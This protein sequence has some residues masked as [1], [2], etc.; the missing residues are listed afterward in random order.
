VRFTAT[1]DPITS[2]VFI[3]GS[4]LP[5]CHATV[6][7]FNP[8]GTNFILRSAQDMPITRGT[9]HVQDTEAPFDQL[10]RY[11]VLV[12]IATSPADNQLIQRNLIVNPSFETNTTSWTAGTG[13]TI[14]RVTL[15]SAGGDTGDTVPFDISDIRPTAGNTLRLAIPADPMS[16]LAWSPSTSQWYVS[17]NKP[18]TASIAQSTVI[19]RVSATGVFLDSMVLVNG[20]PGDQ[21][22]VQLINGEIWVWTNYQ[23]VDETTNVVMA[24]D[25]ARVRYSPGDKI[26]GDLTSADLVLLN[27]FTA[28]AA[29]AKLDLANDYVLL[30][31]ESGT[32]PTRTAT[33]TRRKYSEM[34]TSTNTTYGQVGPFDIDLDNPSGS[35][36]THQGFALKQDTL[37]R[38]TGSADENDPYEIKAYTITGTGIDAPDAALQYTVDVSQTGVPADGSPVGDYYEGGGLSLYR[39][40]S[41]ELVLVQGISTGTSTARLNQPYLY[42]Q[43]ASEAVGSVG[44][45]A[46]VGKNVL[47]ATPRTTQVGDSTTDPPDAPIARI[48]VTMPVNS[49]SQSYEFSLNTRLNDDPLSYDFESEVTIG[50]DPVTWGDVFSTYPNWALP[51][52]QELTWGDLTYGYIADVTDK[53]LPVVVQPD[54]PGLTSPDGQWDPVAETLTVPQSRIDT[55]GI[56]Y[57]INPTF[58]TAASPSLTGYTAAVTSGTLPQLSTVIIDESQPSDDSSFSAVPIM[59]SA[60]QVILAATSVN[61]TVRFTVTGLTA[62]QEY[63]AVTDLQL[64]I[65]ESMWLSTHNGN[66]MSLGNVGDEFNDWMS[67][68]VTF[69]AAS[70]TETITMLFA[71]NTAGTATIDHVLVSG[72]SVDYFDGDMPLDDEYFYT[73]LGTPHQSQSRRTA[74]AM[75]LAPT[76]DPNPE[77]QIGW[78]VSPI[79]NVPIKAVVGVV[80]PDGNQLIEPVTQIISAGG[81][82]PAPTNLQSNM[83]LN[84]TVTTLGGWMNMLSTTTLSLGTT[85]PISA[86]SSALSTVTTS[87]SDYI[88]YLRLTGGYLSASDPD[89]LSQPEF[90]AITPI[91][92]KVMSW[93]MSMK[94]DLDWEAHVGLYTV[95]IDGNQIDGVMETFT[96]V[97]NQVNRIGCTFLVPPGSVGVFCDVDVDKTVSGMTVIGTRTWLDNLLVELDSGRTYEPADIMGN[98]SAGVYDPAW[99][100]DGSMSGYSWSGVAG[101]STTIVNATGP[102]VSVLLPIADTTDWPP[103]WQPYVIVEAV[104]AKLEFAT[105]YHVYTRPLFS[106]YQIQ[107][108]AR[109][110]DPTNHVVATLPLIDDAVSVIDWTNA[111]W[112]FTMPPT[113]AGTYKIEV[114]PQLTWEGARTAWQLDGVMLQKMP[115]QD[116]ALSYL[117]GSMPVPDIGI[118]GWIAPEEQS[119]YDTDSGNALIRWTGTAHASTSEFLG[120]SAVT[121]VREAKLDVSSAIYLNLLPDCEPINL[122]DPMLP[123]LN[124]WFTLQLISELS[125]E[126]RNVSY[127]VLNRHAPVVLSQVRSTATGSLTLLLKTLNERQRLMDLVATGR[128]LLLRNPD[129]AYPESDWYLAI[130]NV[131]ESRIAPDHRLAYRVFTLEFAVV[132]R[133]S[134]PI[135]TRP[136]VTWDAVIAAYTSWGPALAPNSVLAN[137]KTWDELIHTQP[138]IDSPLEL[139]GSYD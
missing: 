130:G 83:A 91:P 110:L 58:G 78:S 55:M 36:R 16:D 126:S 33:Y 37:Y 24:N 112:T 90:Q 29:T 38:Y 17:Q 124:T 48:N 115:I 137:V 121:A 95:D 32:S 73:W 128:T 114:V 14:S 56:N 68:S 66:E 119:V 13:R 81:T 60:L 86:P 57:V 118:P 5:Q 9:F 116:G 63:H 3:D 79:D 120:A 97:A 71:N 15:L 135:A 122:T 39:R 35:G 84:P 20:G 1:P 102:A 82:A 23:T 75:L 67:D 138:K 72:T 41:G 125:Y 111:R 50:T 10:L 105:T 18:G 136:K 88:A 93:S 53:W 6:Y 26:K 2:S 31:Q 4:D 27:K 22:D 28:A 19:S 123:S 45:S 113:V 101:Q 42:T 34:L 21:I 85:S 46:W 87:S 47:R 80:D 70:T 107:V 92:G 132:D 104:G 96:G 69:V 61:P 25:L 54:D 62:G 30:R 44:E 43:P 40:S 108:Y 117:D 100:C 12:A 103:D 76:L 106:P 99:Y 59:E 52:S 89:D 49:S 94:S 7:R 64:S 65:G 51:L 11:V 134:G 131:T 77:T 8:D 109:V 74:H 139:A 133:P 127:T 129:P 98:H